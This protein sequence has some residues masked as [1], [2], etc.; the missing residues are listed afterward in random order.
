VFYTNLE[1]QARKFLARVVRAERFL[2]FA[3]FMIL[4]TVVFAD[5]AS[6]EITGTGLHWARQAGVY[7]NLFVVMFGIG[8]ASAHGA[9]LR[10]RFADHWLPS[11]WEPA[12]I[13][14]QEGLMALFCLAFAA[15]AVWVVMGS[16]ALGERSVVLGFAIWPF[17]AIIPL[18][19]MIAG[20]RH[21]AYAAFTSLRPVETGLGA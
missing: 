1:E 14:I 9:H 10:P 12:L 8:I 16:Y 18:V 19:F 3:A 7:A 11:S 2:S 4:I 20:I 6:R 21:T 15:V 5:V 13:R 17:Q